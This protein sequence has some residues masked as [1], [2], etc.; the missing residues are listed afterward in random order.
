MHFDGIPT[1]AMANAP[2]IIN[3]H[4]QMSFLQRV[5][6]ESPNNV[7]SQKVLFILNHSDNNNIMADMARKKVSTFFSASGIGTAQQSVI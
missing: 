5:P 2:Q 3:R 6:T 4:L 7:P 1:S